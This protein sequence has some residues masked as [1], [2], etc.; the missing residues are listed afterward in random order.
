M[1]LFKHTINSLPR[2][3]GWSGNVG[4][5]LRT[6]HKPMLPG[7]VDMCVSVAGNDEQINT[8]ASDFAMT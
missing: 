5:C 3:L 4:I 1:Y 2:Q 6:T 8:Y 7:A